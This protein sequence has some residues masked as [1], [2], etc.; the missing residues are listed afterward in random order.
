MKNK[1][2]I[3]KGDNIFIYMPNIPMSVLAM[4]TCS[5]M[6]AVHYV[7]YAGMPAKELAKRLDECEPKLVFTCSGGFET[8]TSDKRTE[9]NPYKIVKYAP[10]LEEAFG[11]VTKASKDVPR[12]CYQRMELGGVLFDEDLDEDKYHDYKSF[13][14]DDEWDEDDCDPVP[15]NHPL[16]G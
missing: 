10:I 7:A 13:L 3:A 6:G 5:K 9:E 4:L 2:N 8:L 12:L 16:Y 14:E 11:M 1:F 15:A